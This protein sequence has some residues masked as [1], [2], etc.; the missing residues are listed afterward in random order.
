MLCDKF[1]LLELLDLS[2]RVPEVGAVNFNILHTVLTTLVI[3]LHLDHLRPMCFIQDEV[4]AQAA[5]TKGKLEDPLVR[6]R[7][8]LKSSM[9][10]EDIKGI[11]KTADLKNIGLETLKPLLKDITKEVI[12]EELS[13]EVDEEQE[14]EEEEMSEEDEGEPEEEEE[15]SPSSEEA[16]PSTSEEKKPKDLRLSIPYLTKDRDLDEVTEED[17]AAEVRAVAAEILEQTSDKGAAAKELLEGSAEEEA[18]KV[19]TQALKVL[20]NE[21]VFS[22]DP[23]KVIQEM[24]RAINI[25]RRMDGA[26]EGMRE[27]SSI[28]D[29]ILDKLQ[30]VETITNQEKSTLDE[31]EELFERMKR[32]ETECENLGIKID[33]LD[34][35]TASEIERLQK[36]MDRLTAELEGYKEALNDLESKHESLCERVAYKEDLEELEKHMS[37]ELESLLKGMEKR[38]RELQEAMVAKEDFAEVLQRIDTLEGDKVSREELGRLLEPGFIDSLL[39]EQ[40]N[41]RTELEEMKENLASLDENLKNLITRIDEEILKDIQDAFDGIKAT[42]SQ[43]QAKLNTLDADDINDSFARLEEQADMIIKELEAIRE[44]QEKFEQ[45]AKA[46]FKKISDVSTLLDK[47]DESKADKSEMY[48]LLASKADLELVMSKLDRSEFLAVVKDMEESIQRLTIT[49]KINEEEMHDNF[50]SIRKDLSFKMYTEDFIVGTEPIR[51]RIKAMM[52]EQQKIKEIALQNFFPDAPGVT[53]CI[54]C[55]RAANLVSLESTKSTMDSSPVRLPPI[56]IDEVPIPPPDKPRIQDIHQLPVLFAN[57]RPQVGLTHEKRKKDID[58]E[59]DAYFSTPGKLY[60]IGGEYTKTFPQQRGV[61]F[62][63]VTTAREKKLDALLQGEDKK[64]YKG[65]VDETSRDVTDESRR[66]TTKED[67]L[68]NSTSK[69][70]SGAKISIPTNRSKQAISQPKSAGT[71]QSRTKEV[72][73]NSVA[74]GMKITPLQPEK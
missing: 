72:I 71:S 13:A 42:I 5:V 2:L 63:T 3:E 41:L 26:E 57:A 66:M 18:G 70:H 59:I 45:E 14:S 17:K 20:T 69:V 37:E 1:T 28:V 64:Y 55:K 53:K 8:G 50:R 48:E 46:N 47:L 33:D 40:Q 7:A 4:T 34:K 11:I 25:N 58:K 30:E 54:S 74:Q 38:I 24:W 32:L 16:S 68:K 22:Q 52:Y 51:N 61:T 23:S 27:L 73:R 6:G 62:T 12:E 67:Q 21:D 39:E 56:D 9:N 10:I 60:A 36:V 19:A 35:L 44:M 31:L 43:M 15:A 65:T 49:V 29:M